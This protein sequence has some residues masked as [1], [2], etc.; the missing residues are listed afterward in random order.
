MRNYTWVDRFEPENIPESTTTS[1]TSATSTN[2]VIIPGND[3]SDKIKIIIGVI[4]GVVGTAVIM[5]TGFF[6]YK[7]YQN[8]QNKRQNEIIRI[9][10]N[11]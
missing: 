8:R 9:P 2:I 6:G 4:S 3:Q 11:I 5:I 7:R 1:S 10:G